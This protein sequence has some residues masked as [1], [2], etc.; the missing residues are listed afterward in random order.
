MNKLKVDLELLLQSLS[1]NSEGLCKEYLD[2]ITGD[3]INI[4]DDI[5][6][7]VKGTLSEK[8]LPDWKKDLLEDAYSIA[9]DKGQ[10]YVL[11]PN[12]DV[13]CSDIDMKE[14]IVR[15]IKDPA[16]SNKLSNSL[17]EN[18]PMRSFKNALSYNTELLDKWYD[19][20]EEMGKKFT[21]KWL[22]EIGIQSL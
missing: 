2:T 22:K 5:E 18:N 19:Y 3:I 9:N 4:P 21:R 15:K 8:L 16:L 14:F 20:E 6:K 13:I 1:F 17:K 10:R 11:I 12:V 7:V